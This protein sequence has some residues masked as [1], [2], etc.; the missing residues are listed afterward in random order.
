MVY[1]EDAGYS[2][3]NSHQ[4]DVPDHTG[5]ICHFILFSGTAQMKHGCQYQKQPLLAQM[6]FLVGKTKNTKKLFRVGQTID[7]YEP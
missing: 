2:S 3:G 1:M 4:R 5:H 6:F 7:H